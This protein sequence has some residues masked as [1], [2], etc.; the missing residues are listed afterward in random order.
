[1]ISGLSFCL[2]RAQQ[3]QKWGAPFSTDFFSAA[4]SAW[5]KTCTL[6]Q[7]KAHMPYGSLNA[8]RKALAINQVWHNFDHRQ[9]LCMLSVCWVQVGHMDCT[10]THHAKS[11]APSQRDAAYSWWSFHPCWGYLIG[12]LG[13]SH[14]NP[15]HLWTQSSDCADLHC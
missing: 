9:N 12:L 3:L 7:H 10:S 8:P 1:M 14:F 4:F 13:I 15:P 6:Q 2:W 11:G 5:Q